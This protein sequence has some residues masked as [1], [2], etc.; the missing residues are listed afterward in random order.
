MIARAF[1]DSRSINST[2]YVYKKRHRL[3]DKFF[4]SD[5]GW[6]FGNRSLIRQ[7]KAFSQASRVGHLTV[8]VSCWRFLRGLMS[9]RTVQCHIRERLRNRIT[10]GLISVSWL[11]ERSSWS[12]APRSTSAALYIWHR[13]SMWN[14]EFLQV[15]LLPLSNPC[16]E[17]GV[18]RRTW[19]NE[20]WR[21]AALSISSLDVL[22]VTLPWDSE[23]M[24]S[25]C[26]SELNFWMMK[27][28]SKDIQVCSICSISVASPP[29]VL[30]SSPSATRKT[31]IFWN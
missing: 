6:R 3:L 4:N 25:I 5:R 17:V 27:M 2:H 28:S 24:N 7:R 21:S 23:A 13:R 16:I 14:S 18:S 31:G 11:P 12:P 20:K 10:V 26:Q 19:W 15:M 29:R 8:E 1:A 22:E 9:V 30:P